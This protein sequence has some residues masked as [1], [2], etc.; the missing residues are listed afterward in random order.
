MRAEAFFGSAAGTFAGQRTFSER[1]NA[2]GE[3]SIMGIAP[4]IWEFD[5][6][7]PGELPESVVLPIR[8]L[9]ASGPN[10]GGQLLTWQLVLKPVPP[11]AGEAG[12]TL[13][14]ALDAAQA[15][16]ADQVRS[17]LARVSEDADADYLAGAGRIALLARDMG[18]ARTL[19]QRALERDPS[20][21]SRGARHG[22]HVSAAARFRQ[23]LARLRRDAQPHARQGR[24]EVSDLRHQRSRH[25][26]SPVTMRITRSRALFARASKILPGGVDSPVRAF[27]SVGA[28]PLFIRRAAG[29]RL[30]DVDGNTF[31][32]YVMSWGPLIHGHAPRGLLKAI[33][34]AAREGTSFGAPSPLEV[35]L[36]ERVR[37]LMPSI[38]RVRF[39][40]SGTEAAMSA[41]RVARAATGRERIIKFAG[42]YHGHADQFLVQAG[43]GALTLGVPTSPGVT[44]GAAGDTLIA[45]VQR[46]AVGAPAVR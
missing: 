35:E 27:T 46:F 13:A 45:C 4:G 37:R 32:D 1:T 17:L 6:V 31:I 38:E 24:T 39:V 28:S 29:C 25:H 30:E 34:A 18:L 42:C 43:S 16:H 44:R 19:F 22:V 41:V 2:K 14:A 5:V 20:S 8:L 21:V 11:P 26:Q 12:T 7:A 10:A 36:G 40:S 9:T 23:R 3:W 15:G 33:A